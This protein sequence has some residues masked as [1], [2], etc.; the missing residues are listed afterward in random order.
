MK[1]MEQDGVYEHGRISQEEIIKEYGK[2]S[3]WVYPTEFPEISCITAMKTQAMGCIPVTTNF[4][5]L[6]ETVQ[7]GLKVNSDSIYTDRDAQDEFVSG[8]VNLLRKPPTEDKRKPMMDWTRK[9]F[10][11]DLVAKNWNDLWK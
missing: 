5:A 2:A 6:N 11:W 8:V 9:Q 7:F 1:L 10:S 4:G 3:I